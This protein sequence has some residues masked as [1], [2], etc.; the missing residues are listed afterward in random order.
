MAEIVMSSVFLDNIQAAFAAGQRGEPQNALCHLH[1][2]LE[3]MPETARAA[4]L[5]AGVYEHC[6]A[7]REAAKYY[8]KSLQYDV[9]DLRVWHR[10]GVVRLAYDDFEG[11]LAALRYVCA[12]APREGHYAVDYSMA[13]ARVGQFEEALQAAEHALVLNP[14]DVFALNNAGHALQSLNQ[15]QR[16]LAYYDRAVALAPEQPCVRFGRATAL[17]KSGDFQQG[18]REYEWRW[19]DC[20]NVRTDVMA[21]VWEGESLVEKTILVHHEQGYGDS[22]QFLRLI[23]L[24]AQTGACI[25]LQVPPAL[26]RLAELVEG[27]ADVCAILDPGQHVD[28]HCPLLSL[29]A[30]MVSAP[31]ENSKLPYLKLKAEDNLVKSVVPYRK[32]VVGLVWAGDPRPHDTKARQ[33]DYRRSL[34]LDI[35][36]PLFAFDSVEYVSFQMGE[37]RH[38]RLKYAHFLAD[39]TEGITDFYETARR[40]SGVDLLITVDTSIAHLMG[41][42]GRPVWLLSRY[43][44]CWRWGECGE[45][46]EWYPSMRIFRQA[47]PGEW[48][49]PVQDVV[50]SLHE[51]VRLKAAVE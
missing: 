50:R 44:A 36:A 7:W 42:L 27:V 39:G 11:A 5:V 31:V 12:A 32:L 35:L 15:S 24:L 14:D 3:Q 20:Q 30:R 17:L 1:I 29:P 25:I 6:A 10:L 9:T 19:K 45:E 18:W 22:L 13:L 51:M 23:P 4:F 43:D 37:A 41:G 38:Q 40:L 49:Q 46:T 47:K 26:F 33:T 21:P 16:A 48:A 34:S 2:A 28:V 8:V